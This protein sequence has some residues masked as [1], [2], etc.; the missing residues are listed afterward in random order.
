MELCLDLRNN[1]GWEPL[2]R[3]SRLRRLNVRHV[4][5]TE[6]LPYD[7]AWGHSELEVRLGAL[8]VGGGPALVVERLGEGLV[9]GCHGFC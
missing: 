1:V 5:D 8:C 6:D 9:W 7:G 3:C 4:L 2:R